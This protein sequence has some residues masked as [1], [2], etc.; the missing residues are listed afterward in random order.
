MAIPAQQ[1]R[2]IFTKLMLER[3]QEIIPAPSFL[4]S[5]FPVRVASSLMVSIEVQRGTEKIA[6]DVQRGTPGNGN[7]FSRSTEKMYIPPFYKEWFDITQMDNY[8][9][10]FGSDNMTGDQVGNLA[11]AAAEKY[12]AL[13]AKIERSKELLVSNVLEAGTIELVNADTISFLRRAASM[14]DIGL[15]D[16]TQ[17]WNNTSVD[18]PLVENHL[19]AGATFLRQYGKYGG[20]VFNLIMSGTTFN[21]LKKTG[22]FTTLANY[23]QVDLIDI[24]MPQKETFGQGSHGMITAGAYK[25]YVWTYDETYVDA[26]GV[27]QRYWPENYVC[28]IPTTGTRF[29]YAHGGIPQI[30]RSPGNAEM[31]QYIRYQAAEYGFNNWIDP[32]ATAHRFEIMSA[33]IPVPVTVDM[34]Y[35][36]KATGTV[37]PIGG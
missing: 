1:A 36:M 29:V 10:V 32:Q 15:T 2:A 14:V 23:Q 16:T 5:F 20:G 21:Y 6:V 19:V 12:A 35:T 31:P 7:Q 30:M 13:Q 9:V 18:V 17:Y 4:K 37:N 34:I 27:T 25:F 24:V 28:M 8:D 22:Y 26:N 11:M 33:P 3:Y